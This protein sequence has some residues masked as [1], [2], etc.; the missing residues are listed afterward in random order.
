MVRFKR[1]MM[2]MLAGLCV[3]GA[4]G[5]TTY[6]KF[7][8]E[9]APSMSISRFLDDVGLDFKTYHAMMA[10]IA[11][12]GLYP[13]FLEENAQRYEAFQA[14]NPDMPFGTVIAY[15]NVNVDI[16]FYNYVE[17]VP[18]PYENSVLVNK[19]FALPSGWMPEDFVNIGSGHRLRE[20]AAEY[21]AKMRAAIAQEGM[22]LQIIATFRS[23]QTQAGTHSRG[24]SR[25]GLASAD[26]QF[27]RAGHSEHQTGLA[28]D[29]LHRSGFQFMTQ[30]RFQY[31]SE[32]SW[33]MEN[34]HKFGFI[35]RYPYEY[36]HIHGYIFEPWHWRFVGV[37]IATAMHNEGIVLLEEFYGRYLAPAVLERVRRDFFSHL[38]C[39]VCE[40]RWAFENFVLG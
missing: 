32:F 2:L 31:R 10:D 15:V 14:K 11:A 7:D 3:Q 1:I 25:H 16:G 13:H 17:I 36:R 21:F 27:A 40:K 9:D 5:M 37:E 26:R 19:N 22:R 23:Y 39:S 6:E 38:I 4:Y 28:V 12:T 35:L 30:A 24:V 29:V 20:D 18:D 8:I 34:A 33:L